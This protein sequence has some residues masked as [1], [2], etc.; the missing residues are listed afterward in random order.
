MIW[1][2]IVQPFA[3]FGFMR[4]ALLGCLAVSLAARSA[5]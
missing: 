2:A 3:D 4:R 1:D 5:F